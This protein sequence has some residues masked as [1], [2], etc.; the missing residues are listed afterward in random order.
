MATLFDRLGGA[1]AI[2]KAVDVFYNKVMADHRINHWFSHMD[3]HAQRKKQSTFLTTALGGPSTYSGRDM[4]AAHQA[5]VDRGLGD[6]DFDAVV[7]N[8]ASTLTE[9]GIDAS[10]IGEVA[11]LLES[12]RDIVLCRNHPP[13]L[14]D[15]LGGAPAIEKAVDVFYNKVMADHRINHWFSH[16]DMHAQRKKQSTFLTTALGGPSTY[17]GRDMAAA[18][19]ALVDRGLGDADFDAVVENLAS[20]LTELG[21]DASLIGE[22]ATLLESQRDTVLCRTGNPLIHS[23]FSDGGTWL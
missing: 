9:L 21:I 6:A 20:T 15:R 5:L 1:P 10:L 17:S 13:T 16:M 23:V 8:L 12:Q 14:F 4:A 7:E 18:H 3:M 11:T 19:Q 2:E 22:V